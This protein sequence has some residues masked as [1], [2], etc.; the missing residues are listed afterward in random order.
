[1]FC[2]AQILDQLDALGLAETTLVLFV[3]DNGPENGVGNAT[4]YRGRKRD[5]FEGG[6]AVPAI[7]RLPGVLR[8]GRASRTART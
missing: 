2:F 7:A 6:L 3:S 5:L 8:A 4:P 1:M